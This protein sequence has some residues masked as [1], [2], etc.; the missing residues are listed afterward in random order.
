MASTTSKSYD[1]FIS[2]TPADTALAASLADTFRLNGLEPFTDQEMLTV[3]NWSNAIWEALAGSK[4]LVAILSH[5]EP[6]PSMGVEIGAAQAWSKPIYVMVTDP[7][8]TRLPVSLAHVRIVSPGGIEEVIH[9]IKRA[10]IELNDDDR[11]VLGDVYGQMGVP[12]D[13]FALDQRHLR[14]IT[15]EF[16]RASG[17][18]LTGERLLSELLRMRKRGTLPAI[19][20]SAG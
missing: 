11:Q 19:R 2:H 8:S 13:Q 7:A 20:R 12:V 16:H 18:R 15:E 9:D 1:V 14:R 3:E 6:S 5:A 4:A 10:S 17:K